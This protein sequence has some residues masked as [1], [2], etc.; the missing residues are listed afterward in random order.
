MEKY[1]SDQTMEAARRLRDQAILLLP[2]DTV[3]GVGV[4][5][6][7]L[8]DLHRLK[9][10]KHRP[11]TKPVPFMVSSLEM[12]EQIAELNPTARAV[13]E[14]FLPGALTLILKRRP[15]V[16]PAYTNGMDTIAVRIPDAPAILRL[17]DQ[18]G[19]PLLV[20]S[21]N[22]SG[23]PAA[24]NTDQAM[25]A[26]PQADGI[27]EGICSAQQASTIVDCTSEDLKV[28]RQGPVTLEEITERLKKQKAADEKTG[29]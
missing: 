8:D 3:Y 19:S 17:I 23:E 14:N 13:A 20:S 15:D 28:L 24:L 25:Q 22:V 27:L 5:Y 29:S 6:G 11:E 12:M 7:D 18:A 1:S 4:L 26:L 9:H 16:D 2:T 21:A 10:I